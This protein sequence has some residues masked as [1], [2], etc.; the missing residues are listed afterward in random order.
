MDKSYV[1]IRN[2]F[3]PKNDTSTKINN[4]KKYIKL[5]YKY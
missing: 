5:I 1:Y 3:I 2:K 4:N